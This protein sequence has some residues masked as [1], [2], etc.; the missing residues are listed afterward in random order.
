[1]ATTFVLVNALE[2]GSQLQRMFGPLHGDIANSYS[3]QGKNLC[4]DLELHTYYFVIGQSLY[5][6]KETLGAASSHI[7][8]EFKIL[9]ALRI[10][11]R[12]NITD[13]TKELSGGSIGE[14]TCVYISR[15]F[16]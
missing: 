4:D 11:G 10:L 8:I 15:H 5:V 1:M 14:S 12:N 9:L 16:L 6:E 13:D 2:N 7:P 3:F